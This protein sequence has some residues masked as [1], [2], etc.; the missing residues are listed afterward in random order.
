MGHPQALEEEMLRVLGV[1]DNEKMPQGDPIHDEI[2]KTWEV[3]FRNGLSQKNRSAVMSK[4]PFIS[5]LKMLNPPKLNLEVKLAIGDTFIKKDDRLFKFQQQISAVIS[6]I[7][8]II[9][10]LMETRGGA[11]HLQII[12]YSNDAAKLLIDL[13]HTYVNSRRALI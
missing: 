5:N 4:Y 6:A 1:D 12:E 3:I 8:K 10:T 7:G 11:Q 2:I 9:N 13:Q